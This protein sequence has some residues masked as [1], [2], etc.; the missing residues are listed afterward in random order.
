MGSEDAG[1][2]C[3]TCSDGRS[4]GAQVEGGDG[5]S[6]WTEGSN[7]MVG[8][9]GGGSG[10][11]PGLGCGVGLKVHGLKSGDAEAIGNGTLQGPGDGLNGGGGGVGVLGGE[12]AVKGDFS[13]ST[14][15]TTVCTS[16]MPSSSMLL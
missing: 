11:G 7:G 10:R 8:V 5:W 3:L 15:A 1:V 4:G 2:P 6:K 14:L 9:G 16:A 13:G 12:S